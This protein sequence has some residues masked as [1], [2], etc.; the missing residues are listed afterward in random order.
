MGCLIN[1]QQKI[2][3][4]RMIRKIL[5][6]LILMSFLSFISEA[7]ELKV[8]S[9]ALLTNDISARLNQREDLNGDK[10]ALIKI[11]LPVEGCKFNGIVGNSQ[12]DVNEYLVYVS[13]GTKHIKIKCPGFDILDVDFGPYLHGDK[14]EP[15]QTFQL[16]LSNYDTPEIIQNPDGNMLALSVY[17]NDD[18]NVIV[19]VDD[20]IQQ[21]EDGNVYAFL[22]SGEHSY[23]ISCPGYS[24]SSGTFFVTKDKSAKLKVK[25]KPLATHETYSNKSIDI[26]DDLY[27]SR[28][29]KKKDISSQP[30]SD[31]NRHPDFMKR[32]RGSIE[33]GG[34]LS[35]Y[36]YRYTSLIGD[37]DYDFDN[38]SLIVD[39]TTSH[40]VQLNPFVFIGAGMGVYV[41]TMW[42]TSYYDLNNN[43]PTF[44]NLQAESRNA[45]KEQT[46][47]MSIYSIMLPLFIDLKFE[48]DVRRKVAPYIDVKLGY[49]FGI[50]QNKN[51]IYSKNND[52]FQIT[53]ENGL[54]FRPSVG[55]RI[56]TS[57]KTGINFGISY[58]ASIK[59][60]FVFFNSGQT[61]KIN[62]NACLL[63]IGFD[64]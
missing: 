42:A 53:P 58:N 31:T 6:T 37:Y 47:C 14:I 54:Y 32:Y 27:G 19:K 41:P 10:C 64:F 59:R 11:S 3:D 36:K 62:G 30:V 22:K 63:N 48:Y 26:Y 34:G 1:P 60:N 7:R 24:T 28:E 8:E 55:L 35:F 57:T 45:V 49:Q 16:I 43:Y 13:P 2:T 12:F 40:G 33:I 9:F 20:K 44:F 52:Q 23:S 46:D 18:P 21:I 39:F 61:L 4:S 51:R 15:L 29:V 17:P 38:K 5:V 25:L 56:R 50:E